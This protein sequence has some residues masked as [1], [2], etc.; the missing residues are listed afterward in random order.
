MEATPDLQSLQDETS[1]ESHTTP[2][3]SEATD[4]QLF[5]SLPIELRLKI[6]KLASQVPRLV[7]VRFPKNSL[8]H[9]HDFVSDFPAVLHTSHR[10]EKKLWN[11]TLLT[12][13]PSTRCI[14]CISTSRSISCISDDTWD[15]GMTPKSAHFWN[16][17]RTQRR[18]K[19]L[20]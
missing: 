20:P 19:D 17:Y 15:T 3:L 8:S 11:P 5:P 4:F 6:W 9:K 14:R 2:A 18:S 1:S 12:S 16:F 7:E 10:H 13:L